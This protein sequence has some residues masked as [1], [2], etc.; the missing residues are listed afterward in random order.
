MTSPGWEV[1]S[2]VVITIEMGESSMKN[3]SED[4]EWFP[5][6]VSSPGVDSAVCE[7]VLWL[8]AASCAIYL[9]DLFGGGIE[10]S[11]ISASGTVGVDVD[12]EAEVEDVAA[13][14]G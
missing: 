11:E 2:L 3:H 10:C 4:G 13:A 12:E 9:P 14:L 6:C 7:G 1:V 8:S 5:K